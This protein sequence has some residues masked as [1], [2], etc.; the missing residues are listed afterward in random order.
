MILRFRRGGKLDAELYS[1]ENNVLLGPRCIVD[2]VIIHTMVADY[3]AA[4]D[5]HGYLLSIPY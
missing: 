4:M 3:D 2:L 5:Q 1:V